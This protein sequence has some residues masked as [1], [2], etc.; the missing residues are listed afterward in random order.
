MPI[1]RIT[2]TAHPD[3]VEES[4][5]RAEADRTSLRSAIFP[6]AHQ[7]GCHCGCAVAGGGC[8]GG[9]SGAPWMAAIFVSS[10][11]KRTLPKVTPS[12]V[13]SG[14]KAYSALAARPR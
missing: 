11:V 12:P 8:A 14:V 3:P 1:I 2:I 7:P 13:P 4:G 10:A 9:V 6:A 5:Q